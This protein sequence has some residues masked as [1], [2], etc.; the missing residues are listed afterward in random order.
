MCHD[1]C[2]LDIHQ[3]CLITELHS[4]DLVAVVTEG[5][6]VDQEAIIITSSHYSFSPFT[7]VPTTQSHPVGLKVVTKGVVDP[8]MHCPCLS[9]TTW[10]LSSH[11]HVHGMSRTVICCSLFV[12]FKSKSGCQLLL[13][14]LSC[15]PC[16][17]SPER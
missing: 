2:D 6:G 14:F 12:S 10:M 13:G 1:R 3:H 4:C 11:S 9:S 8:I 15:V 16:L 7:G 17:H 5:L